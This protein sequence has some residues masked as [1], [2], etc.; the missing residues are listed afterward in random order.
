MII[1]MIVVVMGVGLGGGLLD[2]R[3][4]AA[5][6]RQHCNASQKNS[7]KRLRSSHRSYSSVVAG[8]VLGEM[9]KESRRK[10]YPLESALI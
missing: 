9:P 6:K 3:G 4:A 7:S 10:K 8:S 5:G 1:V 2:H